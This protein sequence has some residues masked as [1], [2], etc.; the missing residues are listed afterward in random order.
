MINNQLR[1]FTAT[2][3]KPYD[4]NKYK[5]IFKDGR[6]VVIDDYSIVKNLWYEYREQV[7][8][9]EIIKEFKKKTGGKGF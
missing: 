3:D 4:Q 6:S 1:H 5:I 9:V 7:S 2:C 8:N